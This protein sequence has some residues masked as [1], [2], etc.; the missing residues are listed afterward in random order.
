MLHR[1]P[2]NPGKAGQCSEKLI[3]HDSSVLRRTGG[4][5]RT[6]LF[7]PNLSS[8]FGLIHCVVLRQ[9]M[10]LTLTC[11]G[12]RTASGIRDDGSLIGLGCVGRLA[13]RKS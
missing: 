12:D 5:G 4:L 2:W 3:P 13:K 6:G 11:G 9:K 10:N 8:F 1:C 7:R